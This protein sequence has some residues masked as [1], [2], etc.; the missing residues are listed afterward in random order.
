MPDDGNVLVSGGW[1]QNVFKYLY[2]SIFG[3]LG[4]KSPCQQFLGP[5]LLEMQ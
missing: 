5:K 2:R 3:I 4:K 1:D